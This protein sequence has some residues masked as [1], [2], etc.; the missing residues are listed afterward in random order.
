MKYRALGVCT[1]RPVSHGWDKCGGTIFGIGRYQFFYLLRTELALLDVTCGQKEYIM[2]I[3]F[4]V[5]QVV[6]IVL[7]AFGVIWLLDWWEGR[8]AL[9]PALAVCPPSNVNITF[10]MSEAKPKELTAGEHVKGLAKIGFNK[11][12][13]KVLNPFGWWN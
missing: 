3:T 9:R 10:T 6:L 1:P 5:G 7:A 13:E 4:T 12:V 2:K 8:K 11:T